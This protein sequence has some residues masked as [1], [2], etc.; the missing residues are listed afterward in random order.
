MSNLAWMRP[1]LAELCGLTAEDSSYWYDPNDA[2]RVVC[3]LKDWR[4]DED[5][6]QAVRCLERLPKS[7]RVELLRLETGYGW[8]GTLMDTP[9]YFATRYTD[10][11]Y[12]SDS[13]TLPH[14][15]CLSIAAAFGW[16][17]PEG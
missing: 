9:K 16:K 11:V 15:I 12:G 8:S 2:G 4:P 10:G 7:F 17:K 13:D 14:T 5:V 1:K 6:A 3:M